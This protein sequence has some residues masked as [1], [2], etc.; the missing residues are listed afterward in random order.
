MLARSIYGRDFGRSEN[1]LTNVNRL[2]HGEISFGKPSVADPEAR[3]HKGIP[4]FELGAEQYQSTNDHKT[5]DIIPMKAVVRKSGLQNQAATGG[6]I[7]FIAKDTPNY[8]SSIDTQKSEGPIKDRQSREAEIE[9]NKAAR[10]QRTI[11][12]MAGKMNVSTTS[13]MLDKAKARNN[14]KVIRDALPKNP[15]V[16]KQKQVAPAPPPAPVPPP[17]MQML[18]HARDVMTKA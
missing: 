10:R 6:R 17:R 13:Q 4:S 16:P 1:S 2:V 3:K 15:R 14:L 18:N 11:D 12:K 9:Q 8:K 5:T 7:M